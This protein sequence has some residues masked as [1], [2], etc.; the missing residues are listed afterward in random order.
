MAILFHISL[1]ISIKFDPAK[2]TIQLKFITKK[3]KIKQMM[4]IF[5]EKCYSYS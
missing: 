2:V 5:K 4:R 1:L 3:L